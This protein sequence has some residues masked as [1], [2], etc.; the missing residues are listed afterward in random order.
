MTK[1]YEISARYL[2]FLHW[3][4]SFINRNFCDFGV[5]C[6]VILSFL[7]IEIIGAALQQ[8]LIITKNFGAALQQ[9]QH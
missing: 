3:C 8:V 6:P 7:E 1:M 4:C 2:W 9:L 5:K